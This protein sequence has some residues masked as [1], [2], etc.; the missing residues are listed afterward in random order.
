[1]IVFGST[2]QLRAAFLYDMSCVRMPQGYLEK[3]DQGL[4][5]VISGS[6]QVLACQQLNGFGVDKVYK[7]TFAQHKPLVVRLNRRTDYA[8]KRTVERHQMAAKIDVAPALHYLS[9]HQSVMVMDFIEG[10]EVQNFSDV[11]TLQAFVQELKK[12]HAAYATHQSFPEPYTIGTRAY[13]RLRE[14]Q[15]QLNVPQEELAIYFEA[16]KRLKAFNE[17]HDVLQPIHGD[18]NQGNVLYDGQK[19]HLIDW[20]DSVTSDIFDDLG[21]VAHYFG[22]T[23]A[24]EQALLKAYFGDHLPEKALLR[25]KV[26]R[27]ETLLHHAAWAYLQ[28]LKFKETSAHYPLVVEGCSQSE[29]MSTLTEWMRAHPGETFTVTNPKRAHLIARLGLREFLY[30]YKILGKLNG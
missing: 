19:V 7:L 9:P 30:H 24:E 28:L 15:Q 10:A 6:D 2:N 17:K 14:I 11:K 18:L 26:K 4:Q 13:N 3:V 5:H 21:G 1:M 8:K 29:K 25:L 12:F 16:L 27:L 22:M 23:P 20:G